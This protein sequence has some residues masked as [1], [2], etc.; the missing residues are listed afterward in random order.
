MKGQLRLLHQ[1]LAPYAQPFSPEEAQPLLPPG[2]T[3]AQGEVAPASADMPFMRFALP[4]GDTTVTLCGAATSSLDVAHALAQRGMLNVWD[5]VLCAS[6][7]SGR[8]QLRRPWQSPP[9]NIYA[10]LRLPLGE[11]FD[12]E[13]A[14]VL[15]G[16]MLAHAFNDCGI[17]VR[18][19][20]PND[21]LLHDGKCGGI[22]L[23][24][25]NHVLLAGIG[26]NV[27]SSPPREQLREG[28]AA[29]ATDL[30]SNG[31][32]LSPMALWAQLV[33]L[34]G[35]WYQA[36]IAR[37][38]G[39]AWH[40]MAGQYLAW[41][42]REVWVDGELDGRPGRIAGIDA[43]GGLRLR[44]GDHEHVIRSGSIMPSKPS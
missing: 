14:S 41:V 15:V 31:Y 38:G 35:F 40:H 32:N 39:V 28:C 18:L 4:T 5:S 43:S 3:Q 8:G 36:L 25:R 19:K 26:I 29:L 9:G 24:E 33:K 17:P 23:E 1:G 6:Q 11:A 10:A 27:I 12:T 7:T 30:S 2:M 34:G 42:G 13:G 44:I 37:T 20:W 22:L 21:L 16:T